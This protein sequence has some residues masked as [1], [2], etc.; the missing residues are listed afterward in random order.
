MEILFGLMLWRNLLPL[1]AIVWSKIW[2]GLRANI[3]ENALSMNIFQ[4]DEKRLWFKFVVTWFLFFIL[5]W[6]SWLLM[7]FIVHDT[8]RTLFDTISY[9]ILLVIWKMER[10]WTGLLRHN[11][12]HCTKLFRFLWTWWGGKN[13]V[14]SKLLHLYRTRRLGILL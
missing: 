2:F 1:L 12:L 7:D 13:K 3:H 5:K 10:I 9:C 4:A 6:H 8:R 11:L 14:A